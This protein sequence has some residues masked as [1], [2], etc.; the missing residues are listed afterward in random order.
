MCQRKTL[1]VRQSCLFGVL[2]RLQRLPV[3]SNDLG[4]GLP[5]FSRG[6]FDP[7][8]TM[9]KRRRSLPEGGDVRE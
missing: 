7:I 5:P 1:G 9:E 3:F 8:I 4:P 2:L 6:R